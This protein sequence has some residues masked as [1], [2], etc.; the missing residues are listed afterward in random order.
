MDDIDTLVSE[1]EDVLVHEAG[2][3]VTCEGWPLDEDA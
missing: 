1:I 2:G 3:I